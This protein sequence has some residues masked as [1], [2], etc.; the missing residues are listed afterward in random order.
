MEMARREHPSLITNSQPG[1]FA[2]EDLDI[3][4]LGFYVNVGK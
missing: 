2:I 4:V 3:Y 1:R